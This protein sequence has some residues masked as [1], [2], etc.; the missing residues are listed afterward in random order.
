MRRVVAGEI[1]AQSGAVARTRSEVGTRLR[2]DATTMSIAT[3]VVLAIS[4]LLDN[5]VRH[6]DGSPVAFDV[7]VGRRHLC[8]TV[9]QA[10]GGRDDS[11]PDVPPVDQWRMPPPASVSGRGLAIVASLADEVD[12]V[13]ADGRTSVVARFVVDDQAVGD[14][15]ARHVAPDGG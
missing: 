9:A 4:E 3:D 5:A 6:G 15:L 2:N 7:S 8:I 12:V 11:A 14:R 13:R 10:S 1:D